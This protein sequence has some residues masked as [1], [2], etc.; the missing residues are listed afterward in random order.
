MMMCSSVA[1]GERDGGGEIL[2]GDAK[3]GLPAAS[4]SNV[5]SGSKAR[6]EWLVPVAE[7]RRASSVLVVVPPND[8]AGQRWVMG[9]PRGGRI[10]T[11]RRMVELW[12][13]RWV[14]AN[15]FEDAV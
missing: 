11:S 12:A 1:R 9:P 14:C 5:T 4:I 3:C 10:L 7:W 2:K 8:G 15:R 13:A 6:T